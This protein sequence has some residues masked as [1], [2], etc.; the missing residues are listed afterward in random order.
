MRIKYTAMC[1]GCDDIVESEDKS[2]LEF[3]FS[4]FTFGRQNKEKTNKFYQFCPDCKKLI[5][6]FVKEMFKNNE[7]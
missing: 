3:I 1:D 4:K 6:D 2:D 5:T 7:K